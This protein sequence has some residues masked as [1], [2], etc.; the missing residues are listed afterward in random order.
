V[1]YAWLVLIE[2]EDPPSPKSH[3]LEVAPTL[4]LLKLT[5]EKTH[6]EVG[7]VKAAWRLL[8]KIM[9]GRV[10]LSLQPLPSVT[11]SFTVKLPEV[12]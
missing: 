9:D 1:R 10:R 4:V 8:T 3:Q 5:V 12:V 2:V 6:T 7:A 11:T